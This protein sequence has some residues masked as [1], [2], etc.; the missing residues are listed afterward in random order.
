MNVSLG[1]GALGNHC[2][3]TALAGRGHRQQQTR[4]N[5]GSKFGSVRGVRNTW[6]CAVKILVRW[7][8]DVARIHSTCPSPE[9]ISPNAPAPPPP[10]PSAP[11]LR[12]HQHPPPL[13]PFS[14]YSS[15]PRHDLISSRIPPFWG[16]DH[17]CPE[18][19]WCVSAVM[20]VV[21]R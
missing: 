2:D 7:V 19:F 9:T 6:Y 21:Y 15:T 3:G 8:A 14:R 20:V 12:I 18:L 11:L 5:R 17:R 1:P 10:S 4:I 13:K 16:C